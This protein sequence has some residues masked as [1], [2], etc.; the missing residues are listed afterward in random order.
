[1]GG[2]NLIFLLGQV[3]EARLFEMQRS[4]SNAMARDGQGKGGLRGVIKIFI[5]HLYQQDSI[6]QSPMKAFN[7]FLKI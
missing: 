1:M 4:S 6:I 2:G 3:W 5:L 7:L